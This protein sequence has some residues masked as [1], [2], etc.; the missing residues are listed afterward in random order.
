MASTKANDEAVAEALLSRRATV[1][2]APDR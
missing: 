1:D 2:H